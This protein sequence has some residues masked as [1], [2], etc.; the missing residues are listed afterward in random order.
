[1]NN[2]VLNDM[3][4]TEIGLVP[5]SWEVETLKNINQGDKKNINPLIYPNEEFEYYSIPAYQEHRKPILE[6]GKNIL[7]QK[8]VVNDGSVLFG[9]LNPRVEKVWLIKSNSPLRKIAS[10]EWIP[11][12]PNK[13]VDSDYLYFAEWSKYVM[14]IT[15]GLV[16]GS[17]PSRQR[18][19]PKAFYEIQI[20][21]PP[22]SEQKKIT[23]VLSA[24]Q[25]AKEKTEAV[26]EATKEL[27]KSLMKYLFTYGPVPV[28]EAEKVK[29]K[30]TE[31]GMM[32]K[33]WEIKKMGEITD[34]QSGQV[35]PTEEPYGAMLNIGP[36]NIEEGSG[37]IISPKTAKELRLISGKYLFTESYVL[38]S[39]IRPYLRKALLPNFEGICSADIYPLKPNISL[40]KRTYL[41]NYLLT[42]IFTMQAITFQSRT[43]IPKINRAQLNSILIPLPKLQLQ[44]NIVN[45]LLGVDM[46]INVEQ[47]KKQALDSLFK[48]LLNNLMTGKLRVN[49]LEF[50][51]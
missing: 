50:K 40:I 27:K 1:M 23:Y 2:I 21:L 14:P 12:F 49:N 4:S 51:L 47:N 10:T 31:I 17:T 11:I 20:P 37:K 35:N 26:I 22:L 32:P 45:I 9:K 24:V 48:S 43:R 16:T 46:K 13:T 19:N 33:D 41:F 29:L 38:Y 39:K 44:E 7:S 15:K 6:K 5:S 30:E 8:I 28:E 3:I 25:E 42:D 36:E 34:I 18:V